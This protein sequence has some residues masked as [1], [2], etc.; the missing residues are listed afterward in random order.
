ML[1][2]IAL[3]G[4]TLQA[5]RLM[6]ME[7]SIGS[8]EPGKLADIV[9]FQGNPLQDFGAYGHCSFVMKNGEICKMQAH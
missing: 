4:A 9:A 6:R 7:E 1:P 3:A 2:E 8:I 5:A